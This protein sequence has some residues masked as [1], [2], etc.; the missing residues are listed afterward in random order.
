MCG[1]SEQ[2]LGGAKAAGR[3]LSDSL[4]DNVHRFSMH[5][6]CCVTD[7]PQ[8]LFLPHRTGL[9]HDAVLT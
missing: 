9:N 4:V 6:S 3:Q 1:H 7:V 5:Q 2:E 8:M